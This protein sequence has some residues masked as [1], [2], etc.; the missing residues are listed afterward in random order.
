MRPV[1]EY[2]SFEF[3]AL[4]V[5]IRPIDTWIVVGAA[6]VGIVINLASLM[7]PLL[8]TVG[9]G[10]VAGFVAAYAA[11]RFVSGV[12]HAALASLIVGAFAGLETALLGATLGF[13]NEPPLVIMGGIGP[14]SPMAGGMGLPTIL[15][16]T[17]AFAVLVLVDGILGGI[18][19][20]ILGELRP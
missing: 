8:V 20:G 13:F 6:V 1:S 10:I 9:G 16:I 2:E 17:I 7:V 4:D 19:G 18:A 5:S 11:G 3:D 12:V 15:L 14:V